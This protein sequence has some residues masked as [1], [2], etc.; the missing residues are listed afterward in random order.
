M[1]YLLQES[2]EEVCM[3]YSDYIFIISSL[4]ASSLS[5]TFLCE[6][7]YSANSQQIDASDQTCWAELQ[8]N[9]IKDF[10]IAP[11]T[12][13]TLSDTQKMYDNTDDGGMKSVTK[14]KVIQQHGKDSDHSRIK[15]LSVAALL[16]RQ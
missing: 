10:T 1:I 5:L 9:P 16:M 13:S 6:W 14:E 4:A 15:E 11:D 3:I 12:W 8:S 2:W 7:R